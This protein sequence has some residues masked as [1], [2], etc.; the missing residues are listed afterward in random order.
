MRFLM[1]QCNQTETWTDLST[2]ARNLL[3]EIVAH[4]EQLPESPTRISSVPIFPS[5]CM[6]VCV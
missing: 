1:S 5:R 6:Y 2:L 3:E 4:L